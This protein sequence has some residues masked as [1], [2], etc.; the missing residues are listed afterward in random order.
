M[1]RWKVCG[2]YG[3]RKAAQP[4]SAWCQKHERPRCIAYVESGRICGLPAYHIDTQRGGMV[5]DV[6]AGPV[7]KGTRDRI[8]QRRTCWPGS[9]S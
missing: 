6:H 1:P 4:G 8:T 7:P 5:C 2:A 3:C 9:A